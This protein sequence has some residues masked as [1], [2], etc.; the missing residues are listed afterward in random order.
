FTPFFTTRAPG[1]GTGLGL[2]IS[3][4]IIT[5]HQGRIDVKSQPGQGS[6]FT[7]RLPVARE[8]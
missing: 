6:T 1:K 4:D 2:S 3:Q 7:V 5:R 8:S